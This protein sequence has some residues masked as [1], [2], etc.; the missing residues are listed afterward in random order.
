MALWSF[1]VTDRTHRRRLATMMMQSGPMELSISAIWMQERTSWSNV[2]K[3]FH[4]SVCVCLERAPKKDSTSRLL[5]VLN[6]LSLK[7]KSSSGKKLM[8]SERLPSPHQPRGLLHEILCAYRKP[9]SASPANPALAPQ[10]D[11]IQQLR[12]ERM[13]RRPPFWT[14]KRTMWDKMAYIATK[15]DISSSRVYDK[16]NIKSYDHRRREG[17]GKKLQIWTFSPLPSK[18]KKESP[19]TFTHHETDSNKASVAHKLH[20]SQSG[21]L[22]YIQVLPP[23]PKKGGKGMRGRKMR[24]IIRESRYLNHCM[25]SQTDRKRECTW[26]GFWLISIQ[27]QVRFLV[28]QL[29]M[30]S[31][32]R[33]VATAEMLAVGW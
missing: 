11:A 27:T 25:I 6:S 14:R 30:K 7:Y 20:S 22:I 8:K 15:W 26:T 13:N 5:V 12:L 10:L 24:D 18:Q 19:L 32:G 3:L 31:G 33:Q 23:P 17:K 29:T 21:S 9:R 16:K 2:L 28:L 4:M 1:G